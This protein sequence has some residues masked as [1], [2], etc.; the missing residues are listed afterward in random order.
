MT[1]ITFAPYKHESL[2][3]I[4]RDR[5]RIARAVDTIAGDAI[6]LAALRVS[7]ISGDARRMLDICRCVDFL[8]YS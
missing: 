2:Q 1:R 4:V 5:L 7:N 8:H 3:E 6:K